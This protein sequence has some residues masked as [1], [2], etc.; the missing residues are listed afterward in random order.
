[1][2]RLVSHLAWLVVASSPGCAT[3][4]ADPDLDEDSSEVANGT[5]S[6]NAAVVA[7]WHDS[8]TPRGTYHE[9]GTGSLVAKRCVLTASHVVDGYTDGYSVWVSQTPGAGKN[10][11]TDAASPTDEAA[12]YSS[13]E[14]EPI[15]D[16]GK[17][18]GTTPPDLGGSPYKDVAFVWVRYFRYRPP[19]SRPALKYGSY[20]PYG[21]KSLAPGTSINLIGFGDDCANGGSSDI[22]R[23]GSIKVKLD[24]RP[25]TIYKQYYQYANINTTAWLD[26]GTAKG[27]INTCGGDSGGPYLQNGTI[28]AVHMG[29]D[30]DPYFPADAT[31]KRPA[32][33]LLNTY[34]EWVNRMADKFCKPLYAWFPKNLSTSATIPKMTIQVISGG[35]FFRGSEEPWQPGVTESQSY[36]CNN[37]A[38]SKGCGAPIRGDD[39]TGTV[40]VKTWITP[41]AGTTGK[42]W[43]GER[44]DEAP[45]PATCSTT[46][47]TY[48]NTCTVTLHA[49]EDA[50]E[51]DELPAIAYDPS[52][53]FDF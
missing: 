44:C 10:I 24:S 9:V 12:R 1:M 48:S 51:Y 16:P 31:K 34:N 38:P 8:P 50:D 33:T 7:I 36:T 13:L 53:G 37:V 52:I 29:K 49:G 3:D 30:Q 46:Q 20:L 2:K 28:Y 40:I 43:C 35:A 39:P 21:F 14:E 11:H 26:P 42:L 4:P 25:T 6:A 19:G 5:L 22:Q 45:N 18:H 27:S 47:F 23:Q 15:A 32:G 41:P 17:P